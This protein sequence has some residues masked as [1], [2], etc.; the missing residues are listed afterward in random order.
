LFRR[1]FSFTEKQAKTS[2][3]KRRKSVAV[4][5]KASATLR[6]RKSTLSPFSGL[7]TKD[8]VSNPS[9]PR[10]P[11]PGTLQSMLA[12]L[13]GMMKALEAAEEPPQQPELLPPWDV[14]APSANRTNVPAEALPV[15]QLAQAPAAPETEL[16]TSATDAVSAE[17][18]TSATT[19]AAAET[20]TP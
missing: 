14:P 12:R 19:P 10:P 8:M 13:R 1:V 7:R 15:A 9:E 3:T 16:A 20:L 17:P 11:Q 2:K 5:K 4:Q 18:A 6:G